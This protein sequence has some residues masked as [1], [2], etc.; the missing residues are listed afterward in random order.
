MD[1]IDSIEGADLI[2]RGMLFHSLG[3]ATAKVWPLLDLSL[4]IG[5][6]RSLKSA[7]LRDPEA[8]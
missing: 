7:D 3:T 6:T 1:F 2:G 5:A 4:D 8:P